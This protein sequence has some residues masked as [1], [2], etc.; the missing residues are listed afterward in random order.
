[1]RQHHNKT[2]YLTFCRVTKRAC[3]AR[4]RIYA[5]AHARLRVRAHFRATRNTGI[6]NAV[7]TRGIMADLRSSVGSKSDGP[8]SGGG[9]MGGPA[10]FSKADRSRF[11]QALHEAVER[12]KRG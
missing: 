12:L 1:M 9:H 10:P 11:L 5:P 2:R 4:A 6:G 8:G 7:A 3:D